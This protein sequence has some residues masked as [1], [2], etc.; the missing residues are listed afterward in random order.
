MG[1]RPVARPVPAYRTR[2]T[3]NKR[4]QTS[5]PRIGSEPMIPVFE[6]VKTVHASDR[7]TTVIGNKA[8]LGTVFNYMACTISIYV[9]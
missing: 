7:A 6:W 9:L 2:Q 3:Q 4:T 8:T 5:T 1:D